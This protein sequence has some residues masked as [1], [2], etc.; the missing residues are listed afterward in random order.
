MPGYYIYLISSLPMLHFGTPPPFSFEKFIQLCQGIISD[1]DINILKVSVEGGGYTYEGAQ[2][3]L[4]KWH[5]FEKTLRNELVKIRASRKHI[6][7]IK[8][9]RPGVDTEPF[10][11]RIAIN[12]SRNPSIIE[13]EVMLDQE[14]WQFLEGLAVGHYFD[15]DYLIV[16]VYKLLILEKWDRVRTADKTHILEGALSKN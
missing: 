5:D 7:P 1:K 6:D 14:R 13:A 10:I 16:Y 8:Y 12:A 2:P 3:T 4:R 9:L 15:I 11:A